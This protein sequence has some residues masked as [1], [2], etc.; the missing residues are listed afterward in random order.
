MTNALT[1]FRVSLISPIQVKVVTSFYNSSFVYFKTFLWKWIRAE[2]Q[3]SWLSLGMGKKIC[4]KCWVCYYF[5]PLEVQII[6]IK[7]MLYFNLFK[8]VMNR[9]VL[10]SALFGLLTRV[11]CCWECRHS[12]H[13]GILQ[14]CLEIRHVPWLIYSQ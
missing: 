1:R 6:L 2:K 7:Y 9:T 14:V 3:Y 11:K 8:S 5:K 4:C 12:P 10:Q 13:W